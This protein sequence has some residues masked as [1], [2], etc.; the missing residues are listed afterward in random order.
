MNAE[1]MYETAI[2]Q[3]NAI[4][5]IMK[6]FDF[7]SEDITIIMDNVVKLKDVYSS[8][9]Q[10]FKLRNQNEILAKDQEKK[11]R[12][13]ME[14]HENQL[15]LALEENRRMRQEAERKR[16]LYEEQINNN[17]RISKKQIEKFEAMM[18]KE[19]EKCEELA[20]KYKNMEKELET[21]RN[22]K[23]SWETSY[24]DLKKQADEQQKQTEELK[25][26]D[27]GCVLL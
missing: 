10:T 24:S 18:Q 7:A 8:L 3:L 11:I 1:N 5:A 14:K 13:L 20:E 17:S 26:K 23:S 12:E 25:K 19:K 9:Q 22:E 2:Q 27:D 15:K 4:V 16:Q 6:K 21:V